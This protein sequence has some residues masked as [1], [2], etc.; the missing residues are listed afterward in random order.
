MSLR[1]SGDATGFQDA[2]PTDYTT[3]APQLSAG[4]PMVRGTTCFGHCLARMKL[5]LG[6]ELTMSLKE[7]GLASATST[8]SGSSLEAGEAELEQRILDN[9]GA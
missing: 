2:S 9:V 3:E 7:H 6:C 4:D 8:E 1:V 5:T